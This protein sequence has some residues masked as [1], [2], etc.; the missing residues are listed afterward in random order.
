MIPL[1]ALSGSYYPE[2]NYARNISKQNYLG[3]SLSKFLVLFLQIKCL[4]FKAVYCTHV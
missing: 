3:V 2:E 1:S 4:F